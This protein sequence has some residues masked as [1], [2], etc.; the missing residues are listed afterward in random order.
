MVG[1]VEDYTQGGLARLV[2]TSRNDRA[3]AVLAALYGGWT[4]Q[5]VR[6]S[7][8][9]SGSRGCCRRD[10]QR[11]WPSGCIAMD[12]ATA[13]GAGKLA[14]QARS[15]IGDRPGDPS[16]RSRLWSS[17][18]P[19]IGAC[20]LSALPSAAR[21]SG[22]RDRDRIP[23]SCRAQSR[24]GG[25]EVGSRHSPNG[26]DAG[27]KRVR[28]TGCRGGGQARCGQPLP[29]RRQPSPQGAGRSGQNPPRRARSQIGSGPP[30]R[31]PP[32]GGTERG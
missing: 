30:K 23:R 2:P 16:R 29:K 18:R 15:I 1:P 28:P 26:I 10:T 9:L 3:P 5:S 8:P 12:L 21:R 4:W 24:S 17:M 20:G 7:C 19:L 31:N 32:S 14:R 27:D 6:R 22:S 11:R 25:G 13:D